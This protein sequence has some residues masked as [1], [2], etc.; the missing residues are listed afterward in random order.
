MRAQ[1]AV[2][3]RRHCCGQPSPAPGRQ[4]PR[5]QTRLTRHEITREIGR[6][7]EKGGGFSPGARRAILRGGGRRPGVAMT[8]PLL[9]GGLEDGLESLEASARRTEVI[10]HR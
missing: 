2:P 5:G 4:V 3:R 7:G 6:N 1:P 10:R 8:T 9:E